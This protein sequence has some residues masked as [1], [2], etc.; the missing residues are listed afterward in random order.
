MHNNRPPKK[1]VG[2]IEPPQIVRTAQKGT[3]VEEYEVLSGEAARQRCLSSFELDALMVV[4]VDITV[5]Q[6]IC[7]RKSSRFMSVN[8]LCFKDGEEVFCHGI[9]IRV[10]FS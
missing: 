5:N 4:E 6:F 1:P 10:T 3:Y 7:F 9:V 8:T 2:C